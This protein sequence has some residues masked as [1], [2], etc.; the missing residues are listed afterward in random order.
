M[1]QGFKRIA[2][3]DFDVSFRHA[4]RGIHG[5]PEDRN[6]LL[7]LACYLR[8]NLARYF[9]FHTSTNWGV[10]RPKVHVDEV[11]RIPLPLPDQL[12]DPQQG[13]R[14]V[15]EVCRIVDAAY[16][17]ADESFLDRADSVAWASAEIEPLIN[18]YFRIYPSE[19]V[20]IA[21]TVG[22]VAPSAQPRLKQKN[23][24]WLGNRH[25]DARR[26]VYGA[27]LRNPERVGS[28]VRLLGAGN[29]SRSRGLWAWELCC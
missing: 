26:D 4:V 13:L 16:R 1:T 6:L 25:G 14:I 17:E 7:F 22:I 24:A 9:M 3:A 2:F 10:Y 23:R 8:T 11:L 27:A 28:T 15:E 29:L 19:K 18:E 20:L 5:P 21:D 12:D